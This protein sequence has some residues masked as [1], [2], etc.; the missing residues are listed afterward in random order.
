ALKQCGYLSVEEPFA[1]LMTQGMVVHET[2]RTKDGEWVYPED[3]DPREDGP[4][5]LSDAAPVIRGRLEK[6]SKSKKNAIGLEA[7][8]EEFGA[9]T[10]RLLLLSD[11]P[12]ERDLEWT[13]AGIHGAW[14]YLNRLWRLVTE[15]SVPLGDPGAPAPSALGPAVEAALRQMHKTI[16][17]VEQDIEAFRLNRAIARVREL[18]NTLGDLPIDQ[19]GAGWILRQGLE[20][21][22]LLLAP[23]IPHA[24]EEMWVALGHEKMVVDTAWPTADEAFLVDDSVTV[25][26]QV[27]G[28]L[29]GTITLPRDA[30]RQ[31]AEDKALAEPGVARFL[32][33]K[34]V[35]K[36]IVVPNRIVNVVA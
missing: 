7:T 22:V 26:V 20:T 34:S 15:P 1:G 16:A 24:A 28:K 13:D 35:R 33:G 27:N 25:A 8:V 4:I 11:S 21:V 32:D 3:V 30:E 23:F 2:F 17:A 18:T 14:R 29:R 36:V 6:M 10:M 31:E 5:R 19:P 9:D 12:P